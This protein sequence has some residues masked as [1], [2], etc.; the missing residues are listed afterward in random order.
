MRLCM[1]EPCKL[2]NKVQGSRLDSSLLITF[3]LKNSVIQRITLSSCPTFSVEI[4][5]Q[6][7]RSP[8]W[9][10][11]EKWCQAYSEKKEPSIPVPLDLSSQTPF[12]RKAMQEI[13]SIPFGETASYGEIAQRI[14]HPRAMRAIGQVCHRNPYPLVIPCHRIVASNGKLGGFAYGLSLKTQMLNFE[15]T[16]LG[17]IHLF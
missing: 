2:H 7:K 11:I 6:S 3:H 10:Q 14:G 17:R 5:S 16:H 1:K 9:D 15:R 13:Q 12:T 4:H 8:I